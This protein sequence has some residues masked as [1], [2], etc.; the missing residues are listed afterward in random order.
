MIGD[1]SMILKNAVAHDKVVV[2]DANTVITGSLS[3]AKAA[4][5]NSVEDLLSIHD[6]ELAGNPLRTGTSTWRTRCCT[7]RGPRTDSLMNEQTHKRAIRTE[8]PAWHAAFQ[9]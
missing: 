8:V 2:V 9:P 5:G 4:E 1:K 7:N 6:P 3:F